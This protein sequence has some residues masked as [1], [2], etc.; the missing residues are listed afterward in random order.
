MCK[1]EDTCAPRKRCPLHKP[2]RD[3]D[4][5][6]VSRLIRVDPLQIIKANGCGWSSMTL[7]LYHGAPVN[8]ISDMLSFLSHKDQTALLSMKVPNGSRVCLHFA[9]RY[10]CH[11]EVIKLLTEAYPYALLL[12]SDDGVTPLDRAIYYRKDTEILRY[13]EV[14]T[15]KQRNLA[16]LKEYNDKL[17]LTVLM[18]CERHRNDIPSGTCINPEDYPRLPSELYR[19]CKGREM[20]GLFWE[21]LEYVGVDS[22]PS[23]NIT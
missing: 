17:R 16:N 10:A 13:L 8:I 7:A 2:I 11:L 12:V 1:E 20:I 4:W 14:A 19:Y 6:E 15:K 22:I 23:C 3:H 18:A 5:S 9:A 21:M